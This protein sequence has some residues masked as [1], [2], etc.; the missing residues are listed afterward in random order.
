MPLIG[1]PPNEDAPKEPVERAEVN[2]SEHLRVLK[3]LGIDNW[4][5]SHCGCVVFGRC[6][7][8]PYCKHKL[9]I[10]TSRP[11]EFVG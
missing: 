10:I 2:E 9:G 4:K 3:Y 11:K 8:C 6:K 5:C 7:G 1:P